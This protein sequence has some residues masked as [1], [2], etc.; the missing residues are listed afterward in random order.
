MR[1]C[2]SEWSQII[3]NPTPNL[4]ALYL[5]NSFCWETRMPRNTAIALVYPI[6]QSSKVANQFVS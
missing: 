3:N 6:I 2:H 1:T 5:C 4:F